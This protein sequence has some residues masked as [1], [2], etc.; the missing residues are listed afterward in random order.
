MGD[1]FHSGLTSNID[2]LGEP[3]VSAF[4]SVA[5]ALGGFPILD[6]IATVCAC[7]NDICSS[8]RY[9]IVATVCADHHSMCSSQLCVSLIATVCV[10]VSQQCV[11]LIVTLCVCRNCAC[12]SSQW[13]VCRS[14]LPHT[15]FSTEV[16][17]LVLLHV[18]LDSSLHSLLNRAMC[19]RARMHTRTHAHMGHGR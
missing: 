14:T 18:A 17:V 5:D 10:C 1:A 15:T 13:S 12:R 7:R 11:S 6:L 4:E 16:V 8:Q 19:S 3:L 9:D 2:V